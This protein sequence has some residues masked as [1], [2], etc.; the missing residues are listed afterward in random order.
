MYDE[1]GVVGVTIEKGGGGHRK[2]LG[3]G[4]GSKESGEKRRVQKACVNLHLI[5][6]FSEMFS[7]R[8][9]HALIR[10]PKGRGL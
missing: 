10:D 4:E 2:K 5:R 6:L 3:A 1:H 8:R 7:V 9:G